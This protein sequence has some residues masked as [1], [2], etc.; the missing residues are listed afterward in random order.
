MPSVGECAK[1]SR[2]SL[3]QP[4]FIDCVQYYCYCMYNATDT[5]LYI[6]NMCVKKSKGFL[7][8]FLQGHRPCI[9]YQRCNTV[10]EVSRSGR[11]GDQWEVSKPEWRPS[12]PWCGSVGR[13]Q[14]WLQTGKLIRYMHVLRIY[15]KD[16]KDN[17]CPVSHCHTR[18]LPTWKRKKLELTLWCEIGVEDIWIQLK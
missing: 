7:P 11:R 18:E 2:Y 15:L 17:M 4:I 10:K 12:I 8:F 5:I 14:N 1:L 6:W 9:Q 13:S 16:I 3:N